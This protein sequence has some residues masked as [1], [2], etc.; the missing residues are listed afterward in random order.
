MHPKGT[1]QTLV[2]TGYRLGRLCSTPL[3]DNE[4]PTPS[5][6]IQGT[7]AQ[8]STH[9]PFRQGKKV[10]RMPP[11]KKS[12]LLFPRP[13]PPPLA[14]PSNACFPSDV[15]YNPTCG[16]FSPAFAASAGPRHKISLASALSAKRSGG[17]SSPFSPF[18]S[19]M[20]MPSS[21]CL[22]KKKVRR[23]A[24]EQGAWGWKG[25]QKKIDDQRLHCHGSRHFRGVLDMAWVASLVGRP[26]AQEVCPKGRKSRKHRRK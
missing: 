1:Q 14:P 8:S 16:A 11:F 13:P 9:P 3:T 7:C 6:Q 21:R 19:L 23:E 18:S 20:K 10:N 4:T 24:G 2:P 5:D 25:N 26:S 17:V 15:V 12:A 22:G